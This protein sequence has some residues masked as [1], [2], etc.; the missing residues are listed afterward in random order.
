MLASGSPRL[1]VTDHSGRV[2]LLDERRLQLTF[3][4]NFRNDG[5][6][7]CLNQRSNHVFPIRLCLDR[8]FVLQRGRC[9]AWGK[10]LI[11]ESHFVFCSDLARHTGGLTSCS[12]GG[13]AA[14]AAPAAPAIAP[15]GVILD[16][17]VAALRK[18]IPLFFSVSS[19]NIRRN[20]S[21]SLW[22]RPQLAT[23]RVPPASQLRYWVL[24]DTETPRS[25]A[26]L[27]RSVLESPVPDRPLA[28]RFRY[29]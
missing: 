25:A 11:L 9:I 20:R 27:P 21:L 19:Q 5:G 18:P 17:A 13:A 23:L 15:I 3:W 16:G 28:A 29:E 12:G 14:V 22:L 10:H 7:C 6:R 2:C 1:G 24:P 8:R 26:I 4:N